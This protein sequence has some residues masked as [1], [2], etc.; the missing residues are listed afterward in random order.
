M[1]NINND[2]VKKAME[3]FQETYSYYENTGENPT[4]RS[5]LFY[6]IKKHGLIALPKERDA[7]AKNVLTYLIGKG[8]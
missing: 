7:F 1:K 2:I 5:I 3:D 4:T 6:I 8:V